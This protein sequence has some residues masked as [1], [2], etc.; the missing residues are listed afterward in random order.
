MIEIYIFAGFFIILVTVLIVFL[1]I[2][3]GKF[4]KNIEYLKQANNRYSKEEKNNFLNEIEEIK[5]FNNKVNGYLDV[6][7][8][9]LK[10]LENPIQEELNKLEF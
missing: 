9:R 4:D 7:E 5:N 2:L 8:N 3:Y 10:K 1:V 6:V